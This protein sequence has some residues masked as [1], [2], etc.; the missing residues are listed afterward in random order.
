MR[1]GNAFG[2]VTRSR[3]WFGSERGRQR[4]TSRNLRHSPRRRARRYRQAR[5]A[6]AARRSGSRSVDPSRE[7]RLTLA[8]V[9][10]SD[11]HTRRVSRQRKGIRHPRP[12]KDV[13]VSWRGRRVAVGLEHDLRSDRPDDAMEFDGDPPGIEADKRRW[14]N[15]VGG[16]VA[17]DAHPRSPNVSID[18]GVDQVHDGTPSGGF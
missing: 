14:R 18:V 7:R 8:R 3:A 16:E 11:P 15:G 10:G 2:N 13:R 1:R 4:C 17:A 12:L 6:R 5:Q 9:R